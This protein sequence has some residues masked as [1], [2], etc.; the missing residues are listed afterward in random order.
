MPKQIL[1]KAENTASEAVASLKNRNLSATSRTKS[2][3]DEAN[4]PEIFNALTR[5]KQTKPSAEEIHKFNAAWAGLAKQSCSSD[6]EEA[7]RMIEYINYKIFVVATKH[8]IELAANLISADGDGTVMMG[9]DGSGELHR[10]KLLL[11]GENGEK[12]EGQNFVEWE[13]TARTLRRL[14]HKG[15]LRDEGGT[16]YFKNRFIIHRDSLIDGGI[17]PGEEEREAI[18]VDTAKSPK[19]MELFEKAYTKCHH[20][21]TLIQDIHTDKFDEL[22]ILRTVYD[23]VKDALPNQTVSA[24]DKLIGALNVK[25]DAKASLDVFLENGIGTCRHDALLCGVLLELFKKKDII[26]GQISV[27]RNNMNDKEGHAWCRYT[28]IAGE[29]FILDVSR[30]YFGGLKDTEGKTSWIYKRPED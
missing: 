3:E 9:G 4:L 11:F 1:K 7:M 8:G 22:E 12:K 2:D 23:M 30:D 26:K 17:Y 15:Q 21:I 18:V 5:M 20:T 10:Y 19:I 25:K 16:K 29:I 14:E 27:D 6:K 28:A 13:K 24:T